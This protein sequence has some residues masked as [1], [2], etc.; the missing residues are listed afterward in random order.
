MIS[1]TAPAS[2]V[3]IFGDDVLHDPYPAYEDLR[4]LGAAVHLS[5]HDCWVLPRY[6]Q[7]RAALGDHGRFS[8]VD[9]VG[10]EPALNE[11]RRGGILASDP[12]EHDV[13]RG[14]LSE[15]L[16]PRALARLRT[17]IGRR[18][19]E[20]VAPLVAGE[21]FDVVRDLARVFPVSVVADLIGMPSAAREEVLRFAD[22][23]F[24]TFG[25]LNDRTKASLPVAETLFDELAAMMSRDNLEPGGW[26]EAV[27]RAADQGAIGGHQVVPLLRAYLVASMDTTINA[28]GSGLWLL[29]ER[30]EAWRALREDRSRVPVVFEEILRYE[31]PVQMFFRRTTC[32]VA[33]EDVVIPE[34]AQVGLLFGSANR[35]PR[36][37]TD[38][39]R[40]QVDRAPM[41]HV[42][43]GYGVHAC[44]GQGLARIEAQA[45]FS[46]LLD[47]VDRI[48]LAGLPRRHLNNVIRGLDS[49]P[50]TVT[51]GRV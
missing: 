2:D 6:A 5:R 38:P 47:R 21:T 25:P 31:S 19:E 4:H 10:L 29:A 1:T 15:S 12:P 8:S 36:K 11:R 34:Q 30:P 33:Y 37:W 22:A 24:N 50:V 27:Y 48:E 42:G 20:L 23:F 35:D 17:D 51:T 32:P 26:G 16:A 43:F 45:I 44:A 18:A 7:D 41:D 14:V 49:L 9:S 46:A 28:I 39:D 13:L 40:F 3:D